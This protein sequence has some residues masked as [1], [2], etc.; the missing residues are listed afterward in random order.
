MSEIKIEYLPMGEIEKWPRNPK[1][2]DRPMIQRSIKRFG[3]ISPLVKDEKTGR[4]VAG[5]G[6]LDALQKLKK[7]GQGPP[8]RIKVVN[9]EW[10]VPVVLG[11]SFDNEKQAEA[12]LLADNRISEAGGW[13]NDVLAEV[14]SSLKGD[15][16]DLLEH[17]GFYKDDIDT[18]LKDFKPIEDRESSP[19]TEEADSEFTPIADESQKKWQVVEGDIWQIG[20][21]A[22]ICGD[23]RGTDFMAVMKTFFEDARAQGVI[24]SPPYANQ[25]R[26]QYGGVNMDDYCDWFFLVQNNIKS[27]LSP[28][29]HFLLNI[30]S[31]VA[32]SGPY[33]HQRHTYVYELVVKMVKEWKWCFIDE[34]CWPHTTP[35]RA[36]KRRFKNFFEPVFWFTLDT[37]FEWHPTN[38]MHE[39]TSPLDHTRDK[40]KEWKNTSW[41]D[42]HGESINRIPLPHRDKGYAYPSNVLKN[43]GVEKN[44]GHP[45]PFPVKLPEFFMRAKSKVGDIWFEPFNGSGSSMVAGHFTKRKVVAMELMPKYVAL[46][47]DRMESLGYKPKRIGN[48][49]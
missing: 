5:H 29:G 10:F 23:C 27:I 41:D 46:T 33:I 31:S 43:C 7:A 15:D 47:C 44:V 8:E 16:T 3:F 38:V 14:L 39:T 36:V 6:R 20:P 42:V 40:P 48:I 19:A 21:H 12:F 26:Q 13:D 4:L 32:Y 18:I 28:K 24:T 30:K 37:D 25:R 35:P 17:T 2:H 34:Y 49:K 9:G 1:D 45:A 22:L 11:V